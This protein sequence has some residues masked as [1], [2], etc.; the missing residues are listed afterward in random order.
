MTLHAGARLGP[1][2]IVALIGVGGMGE[3]YR[4]RDTRLQRGVAIKVLPE[5][6]ASDPD[7]LARFQREAQLLASLNH[8]NIA[9]IHGLEE[10]GPVRALVLEL[11][12][13]DTLADRIAR[14]PL[15]LDEA[16]PIATQIAD[17]LEAA[18][19]AGVIHR[20]LKPANIKITPTGD[21]KVLDFGLAKMRESAVA[22]ID[23]S[24]SPTITSPA[25]MTGV[26]VILGTA[27]YMSPE[28]ARGKPV[29]RRTD[30]WALGCILFE[31]I[32]GCRAFQSDEVGD[33]L[34]FILTKE[35]DWA[36][37]PLQT[38]VPIRR[39]LRRCLE[40]DRKR[41]LGDAAAARLEIED[42]LA[43]PEHAGSEP[44]VRAVP[45][46][47]R[48]A[49]AIAGGFGVAFLAALAFAVWAYTSPAPSVVPAVRMTFSLP[50]EWGVNPRSTGGY[51]YLAVSHDGR[52][53]AI[54]ADK[55][56]QNLLWIRSLDTLDAQAL[57]GT[58]GATSPF[59]SP[60]DRFVGFFADGKLKKIDI[61]GGAP[62]V[63][64]DAPDNRGGAWSSAGVIL[65]SVGLSGLQR[66]PAAGGVPT[67]AT[68]L[69]EGE[70]G[71]TRPQFLPDQRHFLFSP[72]STS[73]ERTIYAGS[74]D[75][76]DRVRLLESES[77]LYY[78]SAGHLLFLRETTLMAQP[79]DSERL[80]LAGEAFPIADQ[81]RVLG[82][83]N[84]FAASEAGVLVYQTGTGTAASVQL[85]WFDR[86][87][88][89]VALLGGRGD[90]FSVELSPDGTRAAINIRDRPRNTLDVWLYDVSRGVRT[91]LTFD[92]GRE[93][94]TVWS[95]DGT[96]VA[97]DSDRAGPLHLYWKPSSGIG[98][99]EPIPG[100]ESAGRTYSWSADG[101]YLLFQ[102]RASGAPNQQLWALPLAGDRKPFPFLQTPFDAT[103]ARFSPDSRWV[104]YTSR[105]SGREEV[106]V[107]PFPKADGR[108]QVSTAGGS[109]SRW[110]RDG[111]ELF[112][113]APDNT[114]MAAAVDGENATFQ[115]RAVR[116]L[117]N[118]PLDLDE[119]LYP[120]D[121]SPDGQR[122][123]M[124]TLAES[125]STPITVVTNWAVDL[126]K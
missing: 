95:P 43:A 57:A 1:Y 42:A 13:G 70:T 30:L 92:P 98:A 15:P 86:A 69:A 76:S 23:A 72:Y 65:F 52:R 36:A 27:A 21:V 53:V 106:Y 104:A 12:E 124:V 14:G 126:N 37:L 73:Q 59:W 122:F 109:W 80:M 55:Q 99:E 90:S 89:E 67:L 50:D 111:K 83:A 108:W 88:K 44:Q 91:R 87:G 96:R 66:V 119:N 71:H 121:V 24:H 49:W 19:E 22:G 51:T 75:S 93:G 81:I 114:L 64:C 26:G 118:A 58:E 85:R 5:S 78:Y 34:A 7:R 82:A 105:E 28:Q 112:Y 54:V 103:R 97:F 6:F 20:D 56:G 18:H 79:F 17:A 41:R 32:T 84:F 61:S 125:S 47:A 113:L 4:A 16:L 77:G 115:V 46:R 62:V 45:H 117:F 101:R 31:M 107:V 25:M 35:P 94:A 3:V 68:M 33:T 39:L 74:L 11:V 29:D 100:S 8:P 9:T 116:P 102:T 48:L 120:Y 63:L 110:R 123:L 10:S 38:P 60:D 2:E 40:K